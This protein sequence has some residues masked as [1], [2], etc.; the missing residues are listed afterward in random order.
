MSFINDAKHEMLLSNADRLLELIR[1]IK[2]PITIPKVKVYNDIDNVLK[3]VNVSSPK[4]EVKLGDGS[5]LKNKPNKVPVTLE[6]IVVSFADYCNL[7]VPETIE[8]NKK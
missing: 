4:K 8:I 1:F 7:S 3:I 2:V 6:E 5:T